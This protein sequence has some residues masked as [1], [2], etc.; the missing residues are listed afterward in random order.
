MLPARDVCLDA[1]AH[2]GAAAGQQLRCCLRLLRS[3]A[4]AKLRPHHRHPLFRLGPCFRCAGVYNF[5]EATLACLLSS[6]IVPPKVN[7]I[8]NHVGM[9]YNATAIKY[10][11]IAYGIATV[12]Y[13]TLGEPIA[14]PQLLSQPTIIEIATNH[15]RTVE[16]VFYHASLDPPGHSPHP[17][18][19]RTR[20]AH[21]V[22]ARQ[23]QSTYASSHPPSDTP[24]S[25]TPQWPKV[26]WHPSAQVA[27]QWNV[28]HGYGISNRITAD[29]APDNTPNGT[30]HCTEDCRAALTAM[31]ELHKWS[32]T[33]AEMAQLDMIR[34]DAP[35]QSPTYYSSTAC[36]HSFGV[37]EHPTVSA[38]ADEQGSGE[39]GSASGENSSAAASP[40]TKSSWC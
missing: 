39:Q 23:Q 37:S 5:C 29:Y 34:F 10:Y 15:T 14:L 38:C 6:A 20:A 22:R 18:M 35:S 28:Q 4:R 19:R 1:R 32:L 25:G 2:A 12:A 11:G 3:A 31:S 7:F 8:M 9:G 33:P 24:P 27:L 36:T 40:P 30:S 26:V 17:R 13:G 21:P 16:E